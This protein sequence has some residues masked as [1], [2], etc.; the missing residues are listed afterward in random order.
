VTER[1]EQRGTAIRAGAGRS[2]ASMQRY[3]TRF[4]PSTRA[5]IVLALLLLGTGIFLFQE[6]RGTT[7]WFDEWQWALNRRGNDVD[8]FLQ[9]HNDHLSLV[10]LVVY[11]LLFA[12]AGLGDY[13]PYRAI[14]IVGHL[15]CVLLVFVYATRRVGSLFGLLAAS[16]VLFI[17]PAWQNIIWPFQMA[18][19]IS[20]A[21]GLGALLMLDRRDR[22]GD[23]AAC[24]LLSLSI[25]S[26]GI[27]IPIALGLVIDLIWGRRRWRDLWIVAAPL[28]LYAVWYLQYANSAWIRGAK[29]AGIPD[30]LVNGI[31]L[32]PGYVAASA[33]DSLAAVLGL[34]GQTGLDLS[35]PGTLLTWGP[36]LALAAAGLVVWRITRLRALPA[37]GAELFTI[38][39]AFWALTAVT[40]GFISQPY[41]SRYLYVGGL[42]V[43]LLAV[44]LSRGITVPRW[45]A[46]LAAVAVAAIALSN[47]GAFRDG[48]RYMRVQ[49]QLTRAQIGALD[50]TEPIA[51]PT[52]VAN[53]YFGLV[54]GRY[55][56][57]KRAIGSPAVTPAKLAAEPENIRLTVDSQLVHIHELGLQG[58]SG[59][60]GTRPAVDSAV[61]GTVSAKGGCVSFVPAAVTAGTPVRELQ[62]TAPPAGIRVAAGQDS[63]TVGVRRFADEFQPIGTVDASSQATLRIRPDL[64]AR[65]WHVRVAT[66]T[67]AMVCGLGNRR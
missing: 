50:I 30:P 32:A 5:W 51:K 27:G 25:A 15:A 52:Y 20:L 49:A 7:L 28:A 31:L 61:G 43:V 63:A 12:T 56:A 10:P 60:L 42:F 9:P 67:P 39:V 44:E 35:G 21:A 55:F 6:T 14:V 34:E 41:T 46:A 66:T 59:V 13:G 26:S 8:T 29:A 58:S 36:P 4:R 1:A 54:A 57:A 48:G 33:G 22:A 65:P 3:V 11:R 18:W 17:G 23:V 45:A 62:I 37:R 16:L 19:M 40:R 2:L 53:P 64:A 24:G 38:V 47:L